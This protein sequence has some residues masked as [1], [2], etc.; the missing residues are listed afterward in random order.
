[1]TLSQPDMVGT[2]VQVCQRHGLS[3]GEILQMAQGKVPQGKVRGWRCGLRAPIKPQAAP[4]VA[5]QP[6]PKPQPMAPKSSA[7]DSQGSAREKGVDYAVLQGLKARPELN[8]KPV[9]VIEL[10]QDYDPPRYRC[11]LVDGEVLEDGVAVELAVKAPAGDPKMLLHN[12]LSLPW[13]DECL[14]RDPIH[15]PI[16]YR[17][18]VS[19]QAD[20]QPAPANAVIWQRPGANPPPP[21]AGP[22]PRKDLGPALATK[23]PEDEPGSSVDEGASKRESESSLPPVKLTKARLQE[24]W[25]TDGHP[26]LGR[27]TR[28]DFRK[29]AGRFVDGHI[30]AW[31]PKKPGE[32]E[33]YFWNVMTDGDNEELPWPLHSFF[34]TMQPLI[35]G[36]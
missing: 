6:V 2:M 17:P 9:K 33:E 23:A 7:V 31:L 21:A 16:Q 5:P 11:Q 18:P 15:L 29:D 34:L 22:V 1:M 24:G 13:Q 35:Q 25:L 32:D 4:H 8:G 10:S 36:A 12:Y 27:L 3:V 20:P 26:F 19:T 30:R 14:D 28:R